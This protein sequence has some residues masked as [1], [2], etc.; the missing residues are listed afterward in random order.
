[1]SERFSDFAERYHVLK[2]Y[3]ASLTAATAAWGWVC[4]R[5]WPVYTTGIILSA[6]CMLASA[7]EKQILADHLHGADAAF[8]K[9]P[10]LTVEEARKLFQEESAQGVKQVVWMLPSNEFRREYNERHGKA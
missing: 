1:M 2:A 10:A 8:Q 9:D 4:E 5:L 7:Q 6:L 3:R